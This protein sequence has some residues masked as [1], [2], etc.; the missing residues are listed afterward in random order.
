MRDMRTGNKGIQSDQSPWG[1]EK[2]L[3]V[4]A[5]A[6]AK[7]MRARK[8]RKAQMAWRIALIYHLGFSC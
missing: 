3:F 1:E 8:A 4:S 7:R 6:S 2:Y 5:V